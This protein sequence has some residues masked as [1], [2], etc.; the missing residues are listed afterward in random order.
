M[1][2]IRAAD[3]KPELILRRMLHSHGYRYRLHLKTL[4]GKPDVAFTR[5]RKVIFVNGCFWHSHDCRWGQVFPVINAAFWAD[6]R[7][8]TVER[9]ETNRA[10]LIALGWSVLTI[11]ECEL[12]YP[13]R[14]FERVCDFLES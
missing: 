8:R 12:K 9:D 2:R 10:E 1:Q 6:K 11:W 4:P 14:I 3:T 13:D 5:R 7:G